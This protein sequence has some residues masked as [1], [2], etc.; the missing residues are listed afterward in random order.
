LAI[1]EFAMARSS[2]A[3]SLIGKDAFHVTEKFAKLW[4][5]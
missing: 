5:R 4:G 1:A 2:T 3:F